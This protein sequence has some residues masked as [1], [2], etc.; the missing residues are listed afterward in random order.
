MVLPT[1]SDDELGTGEWT[2][3]RAQKSTG[4]MVELGNG[5]VFLF[6]IGTGTLENIFWLRPDF[7]K[8]DKIFLSHLH[9]DHFG[10]LD[11][12]IV[13]SWLSGRYTPLHVYGGAGETPEL[14]TKVA[15]DSLMKVLAWD[16]KGRT[17]I[18]PD[19][20]GQVIA[21]ELACH[22]QPRWFRELSDGMEWTKP[23]I[24]RRY[25]AE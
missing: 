25:P 3:P 15:V 7:S 8:L 18:L 6:D 10:D 11:S 4:F 16:I 23:C 1:S 21:H 13:G 20:G 12:F 19:A 5:D 22:S 24:R 14:G 17:G 9:S 2:L